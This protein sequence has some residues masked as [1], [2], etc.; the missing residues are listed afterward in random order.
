[1]PPT[2]DPQLLNLFVEHAS[3]NIKTHG[4]LSSL[5]NG[6]MH[7][8]CLA[9]HPLQSQDRLYNPKIEFP[10]GIVFGDSDFLGSEGADEIVK[11][12]KFFETGESQLFKL[13]NA[14]HNMNWHNPDGLTDMMIGFFNGTIKGTFEL[15]ARLEYVPRDYA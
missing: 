9:K 6:T 10:V 8:I 1:V 12:S 13:K 3:L 5:F 14:G 11:N 4:P 2:F 15:K 7:Y